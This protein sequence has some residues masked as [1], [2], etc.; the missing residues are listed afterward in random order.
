[1]FELPL[2][3]ESRFACLVTFAVAFG[4]TAS[5]FVAFLVATPFLTAPFLVT[6]L[7]ADLDFF[8]IEVLVGFAGVNLELDLVVFVI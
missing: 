6:V 4:A 1:M 7:S 8:T 2:V 3:D 5:F